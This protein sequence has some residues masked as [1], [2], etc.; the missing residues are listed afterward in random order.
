[1]SQVKISVLIAALAAA[2]STEPETAKPPEN[3]GKQGPEEPASIT[4][5]RA[6][7]PNFL[8]LQAQVIAKTCSPNPGVCHQGNNYPDLKTPGALL[9]AIEAPCNVELPDPVQGWDACERRADWLIAGDFTTELSW[10]ERL[11]PGRWRAGLRRA[12]DVSET[13]RP[14]IYSRE[15]EAVLEPLEEWNAR[16]ELVAGSS[17]AL[18]E[19]AAMDTFLIEFIDAALGAAIGGDPNRNGVFGVELTERRGALVVPGSVEQ[20]YLWGRITGT[21]PGTRMPLANAPLTNA[22]YAA[23]ACWIEGLSDA[24]KATDPIDY[25]GCAYAEAPLDPALR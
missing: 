3:P 8:T 25:D 12:P 17:E 20:S 18:I 10:L 11:G 6:L 1:M 16:I 13:R 19:I 21:V 24:P 15:R 5:A 23:I 9:A 4:E 22:A 14:Q 7:Y 2:C